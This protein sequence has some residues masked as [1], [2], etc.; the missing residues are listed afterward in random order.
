MSVKEREIS[1]DKKYVMPRKIKI[2]KYEEKYLVIDVDKAN[3][4][5]L[6]NDNQ[7]NIFDLLEDGK[8][9]GRVLEL[10]TE[11][12]EED[13]SQVL[14]Q[15]EA[16]EFEN[17]KVEE[18]DLKGV[19]IY[20]TNNCNLRC[21]HCYMY[22][23]EKFE[24]ELTYEEVCDTL[25]RFRKAGIEVA[26][27]TGGEVSLRSDLYDILK[28]SKELG[29]KNTVLTNGV[30]WSSDLI[31]K[32]Y[33]YVDE[34]QVSVDGYDE[35]TNSRI[36]GKNTFQMS[37]RTIDLFLKK[38]VKVSVAVTPLLNNLEENKVH[39]INFGRKLIDTYMNYNFH[40]KFNYELLKGRDV[41]L[42]TEENNKYHSIMDEI[43]EGCYADSEEKKFILDHQDQI[44]FSNCG[45]GE[46]TIAANGDIYFCNRIY[47][48][49]SYGNIRSM[50]F[51]DIIR[52]S[53]KAKEIS[54]INNLQPCNNCEL[55]Y[56]CGGGCRIKNFNN[57]VQIEDLD[58]VNDLHNISKRI[59]NKQTKEKYYKLM[60]DT[61][62]RLFR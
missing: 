37:L 22:A 14:L 4:I 43:V 39:Y 59:C 17:T 45:Y 58:K 6:S 42:S 13:L 46:V 44:I 29:I 10:I 31:N 21:R 30:K 25:R 16:K 5:V 8:S 15:L 38:G 48:L 36:R 62:E 28:Y 27:F 24:N 20:L 12:C 61:N 55:K 26:T 52:L 18:P 47:E 9:I 53:N 50:G 11:D 56:I 1:I 7:K 19:C 54:N 41:D 23:G 2:I 60:I 34:V 3:W 40:I 32:C 35:C 51:E 57:I 49:K 33:K